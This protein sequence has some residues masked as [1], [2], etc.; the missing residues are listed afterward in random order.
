MK[1][2]LPD[3]HTD[4][5]F[6]VTGEEFGLL[7]CMALASVYAFIVIRGLLRAARSWRPVLRLRRRRAG[8][9]VRHPGG[10]QHVGQPAPD[11]AKGMTLPFISYG[12]SSLVSVALEMGFLLAVTRRRPRSE[13]A[14]DREGR[15][16]RG[17]AGLM[18]QPA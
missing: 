2:I 15:G 11:A 1:R 7:A 13:I 12:G 8:D 14:F 6:A 9:A 5:I 17:A 4:F 10:D 18:E 3:A 16:A